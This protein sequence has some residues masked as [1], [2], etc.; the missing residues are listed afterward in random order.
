M[1]DSLGNDA[2]W[3]FYWYTAGRFGSKR[4]LTAGHAQIWSSNL[5][6]R[7]M[8]VLS[9]CKKKTHSD[10]FWMIHSAKAHGGLARWFAGSL[11]QLRVGMSISRSMILNVCSIRSSNMTSTQNSPSPVKRSVHRFVLSLFFSFLSLLDCFSSSV[12]SRWCLI[13]S[14]NFEERQK[15]MFKKERFFFELLQSSR[16]KR[17]LLCALTLLL[18]SCSWLNRHDWR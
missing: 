11:S 10:S 18:A 4:C 15:K 5:F 16:C 9:P 1:T 12:Y 14:H 3:H 2:Y 13:Y 6:L 7:F 8:R 17:S